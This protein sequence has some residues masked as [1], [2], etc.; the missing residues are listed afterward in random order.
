[1]LQLLMRYLLEKQVWVQND[2]WST[3]NT[4]ILGL[5][6]IMHY[7]AQRVEGGQR[8][9]QTKA[10]KT[11]AE[12]YHDTEER[13]ELKPQRNK[14]GNK[15]TNKLASKQASKHKMR[16]LHFL[17]K[18]F[19]SGT[20]S[21]SVRREPSQATKMQPYSFSSTLELRWIWGERKSWK[22]YPKSMQHLETNC[23]ASQRRKYHLSSY[24]KKKKKKSKVYLLP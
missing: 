14:G 22:E 1:M 5:I 16:N 2:L 8:G 12:F 21:Q 9:K 10:R 20:I 6:I 3:N 23:S 19:L 4:N 24:I 17:I 18:L 15:Q 11:S 13:T 7:G